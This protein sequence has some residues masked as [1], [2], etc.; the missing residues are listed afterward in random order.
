MEETVHGCL[1]DHRRGLPAHQLG[2][3]VSAS[4]IRTTSGQPPLV[5]AAGRAMCV[6]LSHV[7]QTC[8]EGL[9]GY[10]FSVRVSEAPAVLTTDA[11]RPSLEP[12][13]PELCVDP[14][15]PRASC[16]SLIHI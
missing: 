2:H 4:Q 12:Q 9:R 7:A 10:A 5:A 13:C 6:R 11:D 15:R 14:R 8:L 3:P 16:L 1:D